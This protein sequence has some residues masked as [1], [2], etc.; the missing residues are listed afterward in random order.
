M[1][2]KKYDFRLYV[3]PP[4]KPLN[5]SS[6][7]SLLK[8]TLW[9]HLIQDKAPIGHLYVEFEAPSANRYGVKKVITGMSRTS[10]NKSSLKVIKD[11]IGLGSFFF[12]FHGKLDHSGAALKENKWAKARGRLRVINVRITAE[13]AQTMM[14]EMDAWIRNGSFR[15]YGGGHDILKGEGS[16]C[17]EFG[18]H[19]LSIALQGRAT[20]SQW[21]R[22]VY[23]PKA[24]TGFPRTENKV[25]ILK[26]Y[27]EGT[28]WAQGEN[29]GI[30]YKTP[31]PELLFDWLKAYDPSDKIEVTLTREAADWLASTIPATP[32]IDF[33]AGYTAE[34][35]ATIAD[36]WRKMKLE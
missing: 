2:D 8:D 24:L 26:L 23:A 34:S 30:L 25:S 31:D 33:R 18:M 14:D 4:P 16:G 6:P 17:A 19:F 28:R 27:R 21:Y 36:V 1:S 13:Q 12:D 7:R 15:H 3:I 22:A 20:H 9:N 35:D 11:R 10:A 32:R 5:W 29:D